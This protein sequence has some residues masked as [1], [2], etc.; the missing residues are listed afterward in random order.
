MNNFFQ[1][2]TWSILV[3]GLLVLL[4]GVIGYLKAKSQTS[5]I[6]GVGSGVALLAAW[7]IAGQNPLA[8]LGLATLIGFILFVVFVKR[9]STTRA[10]MPAGMLMIF[11]FAATVLFIVGLLNT[12]G[13]LT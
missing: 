4:G 3:Y 8:G 11:S 13:L 12:G 5:L 7:F 6:S 1:I 2:A 10:F 9:F